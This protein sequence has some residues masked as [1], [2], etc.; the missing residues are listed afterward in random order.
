[1][2]VINKCKITGEK[3]IIRDEDFKF[4]EKI[5]PK[6]NGKIFLIPSPTLS[7]REREKRR[8]SFRNEQKLYRRKSSLSG[9]EIIAL[10]RPDS[11][12]KIF[13]HD[14][15]WGDLFDSILFGQNYDF[16]KKFF[17]QFYE[18]QLKVPRPPLINNKAENS[19][20]CNFA[21]NNKNCYMCIT[22]NDNEDCYYNFLAVGNKDSTDGVWCTNSELLYEC[23]DCQG[24]YNSDFL[25]NCEGCHDCMFSYNL[26]S[27][28]HCLFCA[29]LQNQSYC[30]KNKKIS[31]EEYERA[32]KNIFQKHKIDLLLTEFQ[33]TLLQFPTRKF[34][35]LISCD[36][37]V[38]NNLFNSKNVFFGFDTY[39]SQDCAYV[40]DGLNAKDCY[41]V[42]FFEGTELC[43][44]S[45]SLMGYGYRFT[46]FCRNSYDLF[47]CDNCHG[48]KNCFGCV[49]L[50]K[51][52]YCILNKQYTKQEYEKLLPN[53]ISHM[54]ETKEWGEFFPIEKSIFPYEDTLAKEYFPSTK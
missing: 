34:A 33:K 42:C 51:K 38:G 5:S 48:C 49:G 40:H 17:D 19:E 30:I 24:C 12:F 18:L 4:Y 14:E 44:E 46:N 15:W 1:M 53:I 16:N 2:S 45:T 54:S 31:K 6:I 13:T 11:Q 27:C 28:D 29:N 10:F 37:C 23:V 22:A 52:E 20:Y 25:Q 35:N 26:K 7:P 39:K 47:Y 43:Y 9:K 21:D 3:F 8:L 36:N 41:D 50:R 32:T